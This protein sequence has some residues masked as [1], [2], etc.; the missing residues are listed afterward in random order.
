VALL[1]QQASHAHLPNLSSGD[2][3]GAQFKDFDSHV[4]AD[5]QLDL[6]ELV[7][8]IR[9]R[10]KL[11]GV[12][13]GGVIAVASVITVYQRIFR[14]VY[15][16]SF[17]LLITDPLNSEGQ[18]RSS[19]GQLN[20]STFEQLARNTT[21][22]DIPTLIE[23]LQSPVLLKPVA[24]AFNLTTD[25]LISRIDIST[26]GSKRNVAEGVLNVRLKGRKPKSDEKLLKALSDAYLR[27]ALQ[28]RQQ[29]LADGL[30]FLNKQAPQLEA[31]LDQIQGELARFRVRHSLLEPTL[32]GGTLKEREASVE[33]QVLALEAERNRLVRVR[34]EIDNGTLTARGFQ[35]A[36]GSNSGSRSAGLTVS[37]VD[38]SL[39]QQLFNVETELATARSRF[40]PNS[41]MVQGLEERLRQLKPLLKQNQLEAVDAALSLNYGRLSTVRGQQTTLNNQFLKQPALIKEYDTLQQRL[42]LARQNLSGLVSA[43]EKFQ[44][45]I[46][47]RSVPWRVIAPAKMN[48]SPIKPS[49]PRNLAIGTI[50]GLM[51]GVL[52]GLLRDRSDHVFHLAAEV[53]EE[54]N[55]PLLGHVPHV[56]FFKGV[57]EDKRF[58]LQE[59][60]QSVTPGEDDAD[61]AKQRR[62]QRFF[63]Q[64]AFRNLFTSI[65]FL[66][67]DRPL[68]SIAL[69]SSLPAEGKSLVNVLLAKTLSEMGQRVLLIDA[70]LRKP[71]LHVRMGLNNLTGLSNVL[72]E[73]DQHWRDAVQSVPGYENWNVLT[74]GRRPPDPTRLLSS[75][76]MHELVK[77]LEQSNQFD[78]VLFDT[79]P[80]L[81][82]ADAALVAEH[83]DGLMLLVSLNRVDRSLPKEAVARIRS[84][85]APLL[86][87]ITN[88]L[89]PEKQNGSYGYGYGKTGYGRYSYGGYGYGAYSYAAYDTSDAYVYYNNDED[90]I[91]A[92]DIPD[93]AAA[94]KSLK[95]HI[96]QPSNT[97]SLKVSDKTLTLR[98]RWRTQVQRLMKWLDN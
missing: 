15:Q 70:D 29:R 77:E 13:A 32:E 22:N 47:Q 41:S 66:N 97:G 93:S 25:S 73:G 43:R 64:E 24:N 86:G 65:R 30:D 14:P 85:G 84:S 95:R 52:A 62:Y 27:V 45:E 90:E 54:L 23:V 11:V 33:G 17:S 76:R 36:I 68:R 31:K 94:A 89:K 69:T 81:G 8:A 6:R 61:T 51:A 34:S 75:Q 19:M 1:N 28:Q 9:R 42:E 5:E 87:L 91:K 44:L 40:T 21:S 58:L 56:E 59:L 39:L 71:Q 74:A 88:A 96:L 18:G 53:K 38:Q 60:D 82:L 78:L 80:V 48:M 83:C 12:V 63:Y 7:R 67:S 57:R 20:V 72:T 35:E 37:D 46:A 2:V 26:G 10:K 79:P 50:F 3:Q 98:D 16:G 4:H 92:N 55:L 49:V